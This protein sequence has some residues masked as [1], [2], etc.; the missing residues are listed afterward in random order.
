MAFFREISFPSFFSSFYII[1][2]TS[3]FDPAIS[4]TVASRAKRVPQ[5]LEGYHLVFFFFI[6]NQKESSLP[7]ELENFNL[8]FFEIVY[9]F[10]TILSRFYLDFISF[11][12]I[13]FLPKPSGFGGAR[14]AKSRADI[15]SRTVDFADFSYLQLV[16]EA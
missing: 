2:D 8:L 15:C 1:L 10:T 16:V 13:R 9:P 11:L 5:S 4:E 12:S 6:I 14:G 7:I 3:I